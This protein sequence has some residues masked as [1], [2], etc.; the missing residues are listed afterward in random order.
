LSNPVFRDDPAV[1]WSGISGKL[2]KANSSV[3]HKKQFEKAPER[4]ERF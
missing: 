4:G 2:A 3:V 1:K